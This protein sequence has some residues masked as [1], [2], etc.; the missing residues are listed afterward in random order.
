MDLVTKIET[1]SMYVYLRPS[2]S[3]C[4][5]PNVTFR[6]IWTLVNGSWAGTCGP[7]LCQIYLCFYVKKSIV[8]RGFYFT[9]IVL[10]K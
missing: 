9:I 8:I 10:F 2:S 5:G 3:S 1:E 6:V 7:I 4:L